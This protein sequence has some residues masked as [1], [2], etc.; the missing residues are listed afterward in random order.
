MAILKQRVEA[1]KDAIVVLRRAS[2]QNLRN[3]ITI[4]LVPIELGNV[5]EVGKSVLG[6]GPKFGE[7]GELIR[8]SD[9]GCVWSSERGITP[10]CI[11]LRGEDGHPLK[12]RLPP[13]VG[14]E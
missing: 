6:L 5:P 7:A 3:E 4:G 12:Q 1:L 11:L 2:G 8:I 10:T 9:I 13:W 14:V